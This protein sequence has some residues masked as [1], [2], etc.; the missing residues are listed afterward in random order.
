MQYWLS[1]FTT[2]TWKEFAALDPPVCAFPTKKNGKFPAISVGDCIVCYLVGRKQWVGLLE[3][4][5][6]RYHDVTP[7]HQSGL[8]P[9]R[10][11][12]RSRI[13]LSSEDGV[14]MSSLEGE[15]TFFPKGAY[16]KQWACAVR[17]SPRKLCVEDATAIISRMKQKLSDRV[18]D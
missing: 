9:V 18:L 6:R 3:V 8:F 12:V 10:F 5:G 4:T 2:A 13:V 11:R 7:L 15:L 17:S 1:L 16:G 14:S